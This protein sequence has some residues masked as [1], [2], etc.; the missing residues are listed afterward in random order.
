MNKCASTTYVVALLES[1]R[2]FKRLWSR[3]KKK[4]CWAKANVV[5]KWSLLVK[6]FRKWQPQKFAEGN[7]MYVLHRTS[8]FNKETYRRNAN[9]NLDSA[10]GQKEEE[11]KTTSRTN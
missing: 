4:L 3:E 2:S 1:G 8:I 5:Q 7:K 11:E 9:Q 10:Y 6:W